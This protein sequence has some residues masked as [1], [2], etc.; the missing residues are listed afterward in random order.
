MALFKKKSLDAVPKHD[1]E[2][3]KARVGL[4]AADDPLWPM[5]RALLRANLQSE[6]EAISRPA[7]GDEEAHRSRG[8]VGMILD[9]QIQLDQV[10]EDAH[11]DS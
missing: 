10:W 3:L 7:I 2:T 8:R 5:L 6:V 11:K 4:L 1:L 9:L